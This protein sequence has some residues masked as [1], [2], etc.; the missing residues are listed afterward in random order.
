M[1]KLSDGKPYD[2]NDAD[3]QYCLRKA[4][5]YIDRTVDPPIIRYI[6]DGDYE[7][8]GWVWLTTTGVLKT[9]NIDVKL[10]DDGRAFVYR[11]K[12]YPPGVYYLVRRNGREALVSESFLKF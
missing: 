11:D 9:H 12:K 4:K 7:I 10:A 2:P 8:V 6:K 5:C 1:L 3:Q